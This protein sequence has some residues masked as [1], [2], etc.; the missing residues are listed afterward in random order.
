MPKPK[1]N[2]SEGK[3]IPRAVSYMMKK[4]GLTQ[5]QALGKAY[6]MFRNSKKKS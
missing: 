1:L 4:E 3:Y 6:G 5:D 2:E